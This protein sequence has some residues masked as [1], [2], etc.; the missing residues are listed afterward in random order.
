MLPAVSMAGPNTKRRKLSHSSDEP[1]PAL[2]DEDEA[3]SD[4]GSDVS[5]PIPTQNDHS[6][7][8]APRL[9]SPKTMRNGIST[10][11]IRGYGSTAT[12]DQLIAAN[13][14]GGSSMMNLQINDLLGEIRPDYEKLTSRVEKTIHRLQ[15]IVQDLPDAG[16]LTVSE[17]EESLWKQ[18]GVYVPFPNPRPG[19]DTKYTLEYRRPTHANVVGNLLLQLVIKSKYACIVDLALTIP[20]SIL[21]EKDYINHRYFHKRAF[22]LAQIA[23]GIKRNAKNEFKLSFEYQDGIATKPTMIVEPTDSSPAG[24][25]QSR[26]RV[27][28]ICAVNQDFF[29]SNKTLPE[30]CC[31]RASGAASPTPYYNACVRSEATVEYYQNLLQSTI[32]LCEAFRD[33]CRLGGLWLRQRGFAESVPQG[34]FGSFEWS[35]VCALLLQSGGPRGRPA[36]SPRYTCIQFFQA[37]LQFL[38]A[39]DLTDPLL[40]NGA[41]CKIP[42]SESPV[43][44][45]GAAQ[46]NVLFKMTPWSYR[47]LRK[48][49]R[50]TIGAFSSQ[51]ADSFESTFVKRLDEDL[52]R[53]DQCIVLEARAFLQHHHEG[54]TARGRL[55][56]LYAVLSQALGSRVRLI[57]LKHDHS[58]SWS[59]GKP[60][61]HEIKAKNL[62]SIGLLLDSDHLDRLV[63]HGP[64]GE[65][66]AASAEF[67]KFWGDKAELRRFRDGSITESLVWSE[68][69]PAIQQIVSYILQR[70]FGLASNAVTFLADQ[71]EHLVSPPNS[72]LSRKLA[73]KLVNDAFQSLTT[74]LRQLDGLPLSLRSISPASS[75]LRSASLLTPLTST[76]IHPIDI[77]IEFEGS[78]RWP[79]SLPAIQRTKIAFL[80]KLGD[81]LSASN[82]S[83]TTR[84]GL[85]NTTLP[86]SSHSNTSFLD[87]FFPAP[88]QT[89][90]LL[91]SIPFRLRIHHERTLS[92]LQE[93]LSS[94]PAS[95]SSR[96]ALTTALQSYTR[97]YLATPSHTTALTRL[98]TQH[99]T[100]PG[101]IQILKTWTSSHHLTHQIPEEI[102]EILAARPYLHP[103]PYPTPPCSAQTAF[104]RAL[105]SIAA[106]DWMHEPLIVDL[107]NSSSSSASS[108]TN[109]M[110]SDTANKLR[111]RFQAWRKQLDPAL[112][113]VVWFVGTNIDETGVAWTLGA[114]PPRVVATRFTSLAR[115]SVELVREKGFAGAGQKEDWRQL[116]RSPLRDFDFLIHLKK[117]GDEDDEESVVVTAGG[118]GVNKKA[119]A[120]KAR[121]AR[122]KYKNLQ[123]QFPNGSGAI[124]HTTGFDPIA[125]FLQDLEHTFAQNIL[126]F[127]GYGGYSSGSGGGGGTGKVIAGLWNPKVLLL[128]R[129]KAWRGVKMGCSTIAVVGK[130][131]GRREEEEEEEQGE[132]EGKEVD[133]DDEEEEEEEGKKK[134]KGRMVELQVEGLVNQRG[135]LAEIEML[136]QGLV[137]R[138]EVVRDLG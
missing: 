110:T 128:S 51:L 132:Q 107:S 99:P 33:V 52:P 102:L 101:T 73:F 93:A 54:E 65:D 45:D 98:S 25:L 13:S 30:K 60:L 11:G 123:L 53:F 75:Q 4:S 74:Q 27:R 104:L 125:L 46:I 126:F 3:V 55:E 127:Y 37:I 113:N 6:R 112:N 22:Y 18:S 35:I 122:M 67:R 39:R 43:L 63:D 36:L 41:T 82:S 21:Q 124:E 62:I 17:A 85:E 42:Q 12:N 61:R 32:S 47:L 68:E 64:S 56:R 96:P 103:Y 136:G 24:Y 29:D 131:G 49:A 95:P 57:H 78:S 106:W 134:K 116:F 79:D 7:S 19:K 92:L 120:K 77:I 133:D 31:L 94:T 48:E 115:A 69:T 72:A 86:A 66:R 130:K 16:P 119:H 23:A 15:R 97:F 90:Q 84:V 138:I 88:S 8:T 81:L 1:A 137:E 10:N 109:E 129:G 26:F 70:H 83:I 59:I 89:R 114:R 111:T 100:L 117:E 20:D 91:P 87:I 71:V 50:S 14:A 108:T 44:F 58:P 2:A 9:K 121:A 105:A 76:P 135:M 5:Y 38:A 28:I 118:D 40:L 80:I 34:G